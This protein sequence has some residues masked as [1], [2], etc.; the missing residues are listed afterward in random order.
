MAESTGRQR[1][2]WYVHRPGEVESM[3]GQM[4][5]HRVG[6]PTGPRLEVHLGPGEQLTLVPAE[7]R[8]RKRRQ[9]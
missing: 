5:R 9:S 3:E 1:P 8:G 7:G 6:Q 2:P 4:V